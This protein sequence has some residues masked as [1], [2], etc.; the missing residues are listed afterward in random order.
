MYISSPVHGGM[1]YWSA[2]KNH[3]LYHYSNTPLL[4]YSKTI[5]SK[6]SLNGLGSSKYSI[7]P[8]SRAFQISHPSDA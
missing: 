1:E 8:Q 5:G 3:T 7:K 4:Q 6:D 2:E